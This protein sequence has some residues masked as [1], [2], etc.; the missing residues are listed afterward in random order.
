MLCTAYFLLHEDK[1]IRKIL[2]DAVTLKLLK[3]YLWN[4]SIFT[5]GIVIIISYL[6]VFNLFF[7]CNVCSIYLNIYF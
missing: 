3:T 1:I 4:V 6:Q 2:F 5:V 7:V